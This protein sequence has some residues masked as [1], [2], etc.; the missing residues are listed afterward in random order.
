MTVHVLIASLSMT[1]L[2]GVVSLVFWFHRRDLES[3]VAARTRELAEANE[4]LREEHAHRESLYQQLAEAQRM[5][6]LGRLAGDVAHDFNNLL[7]VILGN[8]TVLRSLL[9]P[10]TAEE[11]LS[12]IEHAG[13]S[14]AELTRQLLV[15]GRNAGTGVDVSVRRLANAEPAAVD[16]PKAMRRTACRHALVID[17]DPMNLTVVAHLLESLGCEAS[18]STDPATIAA[19]L[20]RAA[21][22]GRAIDLVLLDVHLQGASGLDTCRRLRDEGIDVAILCM[23]GDWVATPVYVEAGFDG[24]VAKPIDQA[25]LRACVERYA[26]W[27]HARSA[28]LLDG[29][30]PVAAGA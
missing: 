29:T 21:T 24:I 28:S 5:E 14:A 20:A 7:T 1:A 25:A 8:T 27:S 17:D 26:G 16:E 19:T 9:P 3:R 23:S 11:F 30:P 13:Q 6:A 12:G 2:M 22:Q 15:L 18:T 10:S 4:R